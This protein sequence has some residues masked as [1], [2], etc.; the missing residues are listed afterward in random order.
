MSVENYAD[1]MQP[2][3]LR[4]GVTTV[5]DVGNNLDA[6]LIHRRRSQ[7]PGQQRPRLFACGPVI[8]GPN[9]SWPA[10]VARKVATADEAQAVARELLARQVDCL[11]IAAQLT[12]PQVQAIV[13]EAAPYGVPVT[14]QVGTT[15]A[16]E[17]VALGVTGLER[18]L[19]VDHREAT[20][21]E[22]QAQA[23]LLATKGVF[24]VP[25]LVL[26]EQL[27][28]LLDPDLR[29]NPLH[30]HVPSALFDWWDAPYG[31]GQ[32]TEAPSAEHR[33]LLSRKKARL[34]EFVRANGRVV[35]GSATPYP[36]DVL[37]GA[38]VQREMELL[39]EAG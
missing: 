29:Q 4:H 24:V 33:G 9:S 8:D 36:P 16:V 26:N 7:K 17:A 18:A 2:L 38:G 19:G 31:V 5:R 6:I 20:T 21:Q 14:A 3:F 23:R 28:R 13:A 34:A 27:S 12:P 39:V 15:N 37:P 22:L 11:K 1:W 32:W 10:W 25:T 30:Q 35:A